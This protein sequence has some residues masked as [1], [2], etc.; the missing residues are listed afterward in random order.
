MKV[1]FY[2]TVTEGYEGMYRNMYNSLGFREDCDYWIFTND[3]F[4]IPELKKPNVFKHSFLDLGEVDIGLYTYFMSS[5]IDSERL[6]NIF[7]NK[8]KILDFLKQKGYDII[9]MVDVD[10]VCLRDVFPVIKEVYEKDYDL[11]CNDLPESNELVIKA[12]VDRGHNQKV[13]EEFYSPTWKVPEGFTNKFNVGCMIL[14]ANHLSGE[15]FQK[16]LE[17]SKGREKYCICPE[18]V[19]LQSNYKNKLLVPG[20]NIT[21]SLVGLEM[22]KPNSIQCNP[23]F[24]DY[25]KNGYVYHYGSK[26]TP[27]LIMAGR[28]FSAGHALTLERY[29]DTAVHKGFLE[30][31]VKDGFFK[32]EITFETTRRLLNKVQNIGR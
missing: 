28:C 9:V 8:I 12:Y 20:L 4:D 1:A 19:Y 7:L 32:G 18:E 10:M 6:M 24:A 27:C 21:N 3:A 23:D 17:W 16:F 30:K 14:N 11:A 31:T 15:D 2:S 22:H 5:D 13:L 25:V 26:V 29:I